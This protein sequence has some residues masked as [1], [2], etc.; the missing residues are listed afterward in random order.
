[1]Q[2][3]RT[4]RIASRSR[5]A[6]RSCVHRPGRASARRGFAAARAVGRDADGGIGA[7]G[8]YRAQAFEGNFIPATLF[9]PVGSKILSYFPKPLT[10]GNRDGTNNYLRPEMQEVIDYDSHTI[11]VDQHL[12]DK[13][14]L[15]VR[16]SSPA[17]ERKRSSRSVGSSVSCGA[18]MVIREVLTAATM[19]GTAHTALPAAHTDVRDRGSGV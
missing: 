13:N 18:S 12:G 11:K 2:R 4:F 15:F 8:R 16:S 19:P 6:T 10:A 14:K 3:I 7:G 9:N 1:M 17:R 5:A